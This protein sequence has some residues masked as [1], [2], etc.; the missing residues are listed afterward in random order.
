[1]PPFPE[2]GHTSGMFT[3]RP[4]PVTSPFTL[5]RPPM[6]LARVGLACLA[7]AG[8]GSDAPA[9]AGAMGLDHVTFDTV[10][11]VGVMDGDDREVFGAIWE[12]ASGPGG[13]FAVLDRQTP[14]ISIFDAAGDFVG[15]VAGQ[16]AGPGELARPYALT[17]TSDGELLAL[18][19]ANARI[20]AFRVED[21]EV[22]HTFSQRTEVWGTGNFCALY[23][24]ILVAAHR[25]DH[26]IHE[27][28]EAGGIARSISSAPV[29]PEAEGLE[30][31]LRAIA[32]EDLTAVR[33]HCEPERGRILEVGIMNPRIQLLEAG[34]TPVWTTE[35][36]EIFPLVPEVVNGGGVGMRVDPETGAHLARSI[37][38]WD[39]E[40]VLI[41][42]RR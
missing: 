35:L 10:A 20:S 5:A 1:M 38:P 13:V 39:R 26:V 36:D 41:L 7:L 2:R 9:A 6:G 27:L 16:G 30:G 12:V 4:F 25:D 3:E 32:M 23:G 33:L 14:R 21:G 18:D 19:P 15:E 29:P 17:W 40:H 11:T 31:A 22:E 42:E 28:D 34:G 37:V 8:C 24:R